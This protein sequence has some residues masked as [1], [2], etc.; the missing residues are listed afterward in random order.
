MPYPVRYVY[1]SLGRRTEMYTYRADAGFSASTWPAGAET[2]GDKTEWVYDE[3][4]GLLV[5]KLDASGEGPT[6]SYGAGGRL[7][8]RS[9]ARAV[10]GGDS[11]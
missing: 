2:S 9:W 10:S 6:Y 1:D 7:L 8:T 4:T 3:G 11:R 5:Q